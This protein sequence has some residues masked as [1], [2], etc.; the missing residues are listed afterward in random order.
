MCEDCLGNTEEVLLA[1]QRGTAAIVWFQAKQ[2]REDATQPGTMTRFDFTPKILPR[3]GRDRLEWESY[4]SYIT[5]P[6]E[7]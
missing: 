5:F 6:F 7:L 3:Q 4:I 2:A 1:K